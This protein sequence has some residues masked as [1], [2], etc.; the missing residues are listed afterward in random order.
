MAQARAAMLNAVSIHTPTQGVT[1]NRKEGDANYGF[2]PHTHA[3]C[4]PDNTDDL[5][6]VQVSIHTPTQGVTFPSTNA[7]FCTSVSIHTPT[8]GVTMYHNFVRRWG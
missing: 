2:N 3:G 1:H 7:R 4:D 5:Q 6:Q 8:Q